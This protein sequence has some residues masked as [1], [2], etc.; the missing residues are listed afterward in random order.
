MKDLPTVEWLQ[1][2]AQ[3]AH[4]FGLGFIQIVTGPSERYHFYHPDLPG[5][6][7]PEEP[8]DHRY[9]FVSTV[10]KGA[11]LNRV[12]EIDPAGPHPSGHVTLHY[13]SCRPP[14]MDGPEPPEPDIES[15]LYVG[16]FT[17]K[18]GSSYFMNHEAFH[19]VQPIGP[20]ITRLQRGVI[21]KQF[22]RVIR[23][24]GQDPVCPYSKPL[25][26]DDLWA[27]VEDCMVR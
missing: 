4:F 22:A 20:T 17:V 13:E 3:R 10:L 25:S 19:T 24:Q 18:E 8:H 27:A 2:N 11:L 9:S 6:T 23:K 15:M 26:E 7:D 1:N 21:H 12:W 16:E 5:F 14:G